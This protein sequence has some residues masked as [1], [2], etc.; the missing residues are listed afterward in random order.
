MSDAPKSAL[1]VTALP[2]EYQAVREQ[3]NDLTEVRSD[4]GVSYEV[5]YFDG[6][7]SSWN[8]GIVQLVEPGN[9]E[10]ALAT[11]EAIAVFRPEILMFVGVAG[12][13]KDVSLGD[14]VVATK[15]YGYEYGVARRDF[16]TRPEVGRSDHLLIRLASFRAN[17][18]EWNQRVK[19]LSSPHSRVYVAP[20][21]AGSAVVKSKQSAISQLLKKH[22]SDALAV[23]M[24]GSGFLRAAWR[25]SSTRA[26]V[27][28]GI[29]DL[30]GNKQQADKAGWQTIATKHAAAFAFELLANYGIP[31][32]VSNPQQ[33]QKTNTTAPAPGLQETIS[34]LLGTDPVLGIKAVEEVRQVGDR[35]IPALESELIR[36]NGNIYLPFQARARMPEAF[37]AIGDFAIPVL[38]NLIK[39][40]DWATKS[41][42]C[43]C[44]RYLRSSD[45]SSTLA[46]GIKEWTD[47]DSVRCAIEALGW[48]NASDWA[49]LIDDQTFKKGDY[50]FD[51]YW[52]YT[53][54]AYLL[55]LAFEESEFALDYEVS[56]VERLIEKLRKTDVF[57]KSEY[58]YWI[59]VRAVAN[60]FL[61]LGTT[62]VRKWLRSEDK[63]LHETAG[64][65]VTRRRPPYAVDDLRDFVTTGM[66][67]DLKR[68]SI[69]A[70]GE[71]GTKA[72]CSSLL[73]ILETDSVAQSDDM[74]NYCLH[75]L[76]KGCQHLTHD[77]YTDYFENAKLDGETRANALYTGLKWTPMQDWARFLN[78]KD[79][80]VRRPAAIC[81]GAKATEDTQRTLK[82]YLRH[83][84]TPM[85]KTFVL[86]GLVRSGAQDVR[87]E[88]YLSLGES[89][90]NRD[91]SYIWKR[92]FVA[93][94][95]DDPNNGLAK[96]K[97][98]ASLFG[99]D[100]AEC[101]SEAR[102]IT[103]G[104]LIL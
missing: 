35:A 55:M 6:K 77:Q 20:I 41:E 94:L 14:V 3:L 23:E 72:A 65:I 102:E 75:S 84:S 80:W 76:S 51:K 59:A 9:E 104:A 18:N 53:S 97:A 89:I 81:F 16:E 95:A 13:L 27:V 99:V 40:G 26:L 4:R 1:I 24:E 54:V 7:Y 79:E 92:E 67:I 82:Q 78:S 87:N 47:P 2:L 68:R 17:V 32:V 42:S 70:L 58:S 39:T 86:A 60:E 103:A 56:R 100:A 37:G 44:L 66:S 98:W 69:F 64:L 34:D 10:A 57:L 43:K 50:Y 30:L 29:S 62:G 83:A 11:Q 12:G 8:V 21:A 49:F 22:Y 74:R 46:R 15:V 61:P 93:I 36:C 25:D 28:R 48:M 19:T 90:T 45:A 91:L 38:I 52:F 5:G 71:I 31:L 101:I 88:F 96:A 33:P 73:D 85:D 63:M